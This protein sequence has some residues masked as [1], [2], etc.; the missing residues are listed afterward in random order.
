MHT[1]RPLAAVC[2]A[3]AILLSSCVSTGQAVLPAEVPGGEQPQSYTI[4]TLQNR[5][6]ELE[7]RADY[8]QFTGNDGLNQEISAFVAQSYAEFKEAAEEA[9]REQT[10]L[11]GEAG[12]PS[13]YIV[14]AR[15]IES[16]D[17]TS[18]LLT[19]WTYLAGAAHGNTGFKTF[20]WGEKQGRFVTAEEAG[21][22]SYRELSE[23]CRT[24]L[25]DAHPDWDEN[26]VRGG[27]EPFPDSFAAFTTDGTLLTIYFEPYM[28]AAYAAG[29]QEVTIPV[30]N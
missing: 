11:F 8:P 6:G 9:A 16:R 17:Y 14:E 21:G 1:C 23:E 29:P 27:T 28:V 18:V 15:V 5:T 3:A 24:R 7:A 2:T 25:L 12:G 4:V 26:W 10:A 22:M 20:V 30:R 13:S 19:C